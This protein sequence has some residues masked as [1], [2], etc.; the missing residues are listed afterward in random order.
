MLVL[1]VGL[2]VLAGLLFGLFALLGL[3]DRTLWSSL[4]VMFGPAIDAGLT[5][6]LLAWL[7]LGPVLVG[8]LRSLGWPGIVAVDSHGVVASSRACGPP[9]GAK[10]PRTAETSRASARGP[11]RFLLH[12]FLLAGGRRQLGRHGAASSRRGVDRN[13]RGPVRQGP[14]DGSTH[15]A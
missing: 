3:R 7:G 10:P 8:A 5:A 2:A 12:R 13:G 15:L 11:H 1:V 4:F 9:C 14:R 6:W